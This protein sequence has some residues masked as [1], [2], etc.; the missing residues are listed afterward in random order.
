MILLPSIRW[1]ERKFIP[2]SENSVDKTERPSV[3]LVKSCRIGQMR[4]FQICHWLVGCP[5]KSL[6]QSSH[7]FKANNYA[8]LSRIF[9]EQWIP[10]LIVCMG[11]CMRVCG[12]REQTVRLKS[13][14]QRQE[15][16]AGKQTWDGNKWIRGQQLLPPWPP[17]SAGNR[18]GGGEGVAA[19]K[20]FPEETHAEQFANK[21]DASFQET[22]CRE[23]QIIFWLI[24]PQEHI[25]CKSYSWEQGIWSEIRL[26]RETNI[27]W[28]VSEIIGFQRQLWWFHI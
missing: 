16:Q 10:T 5:G 6:P 26:C 17:K 19:G 25:Y 18:R 28:E 2:G 23:G 27:K 11:G 20:P 13:L 21:Y 4:H 22:I 9:I 1:Q 8:N 7:P 24:N 14:P 15:C 3:Y 12:W